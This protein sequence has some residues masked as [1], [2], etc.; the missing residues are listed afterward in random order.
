MRRILAIMCTLLCA[1]LGGF[2]LTAPRADAAPAGCPKIY[3]LAVPGTWA[4]GVSP[5]VLSAVTSGLGPETKVQYVGYDATAFPWEKAVYGKSKAQAVANTRGLA[6]QMLQRCPGTRIAL[7]GYSQGADAAGDLASEI[8]TGRAAIR[9]GQVAGVV[10]ISDPRRSRKDNLVGP[11]LRGEGSGGPRL[12]GMG[13]VLPRAFTLCEPS[14]MYCNVPRDFYITRIAGYLAE[15]SDP[16]PSQILQ[17]QAEA[18]VIVRELLTLG[19]PGAVVE[20]LGNKRARE[21]ITSFNRFLKS[22]SHGTY[23]DFQVNPGV[24]AV[25]WANRFLAGLA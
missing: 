16:T 20:E 4:N 7:V 15:T 2:G 13:W 1:V 19:G 23:G 10:L 25:T 11:A 5:G 3:V 24:S 9:P 6:L 22:G 17:Y 8:G 18:A 21:Q 14:D 12:D